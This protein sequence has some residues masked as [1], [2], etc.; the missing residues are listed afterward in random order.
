MYKVI[1]CTDFNDFLNKEIEIRNVHIKEVKKT[2]RAG[3]LYRGQS[4]HSWGLQATIF[5]ESDSNKYLNKEISVIGY[6]RD[7]WNNKDLEI[8]NIE[9]PE[10]T[11]D[12]FNEVIQSIIQ[13]SGNVWWPVNKELEELMKSARHYELASP[14]LD[15]TYCLYIAS[16]FAFSTV[17]NLDTCVAIFMMTTSNYTPE[18]GVRS[19]DG[20]I[21]HFTDS[22]NTIIERDIAQ[23]SSYSVSYLIAN[24]E[25]SYTFYNAENPQDFVKYNGLKTSVY[26]FIIP[27]VDKEKILEYLDK[28]Y[29][30]NEASLMPTDT[31]S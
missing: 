21:V 4:N 19:A 31:I 14:L 28:V 27:A 11:E 17:E 3:I 23:K 1:C 22:P 7:L 16:Y 18:E 29:H 8:H 2:G 26:K 20:V 6:L 9:R 10:L 25:M 24:G 30:L 13:K 5:R 12:E 15:W